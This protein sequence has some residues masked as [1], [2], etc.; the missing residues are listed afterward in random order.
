MRSK[1]S[2]FN[3]GV[4]LNLLKRYWPLWAA[5]FVVLLLI[6]PAQLS[7]MVEGLAAGEMLN[8]TLLS[9]G[10]DMALLSMAASPLAALAMYNYLYTPRGCGMMNC[11]P[12]R[13]ETVFCTAFLTGIAPMLLAD[14]LVMLIT[15]VGFGGRFVGMTELLLWLAIVVMGNVSFYGFAVLCALLT[16]NVVAMP[17]IYVVLN[18]AAY[19]AEMCIRNLLSVFVYGMSV[20]GLTFMSFSPFVALPAALFVNQKSY[21]DMDG[22]VQ[23]FPNAYEVSGLE[24]LG[25][26]C[27][28]GLLCAVLALLLYRRRH[29]ESA[30]D[31]VAVPILKP[32][33]RYCMA[34][35]SAVLFAYALYS[36]MV[37]KS[38]GGMADAMLVL[39]LMMIG[40]FLGYY[41]AEMLMQKTLKVFPGKWKGYVATCLVLVAL[42]VA[43]E[44]DLF[45]YE[46]RIPDADEVSWVQLSFGNSALEEPENIS[47]AVALHRSILEN[48]EE[49]E[50]A[51]EQYVMSIRY[52][53][54]DGRI[55]IRKYPIRGDEEARNDTTSDIRQFQDLCNVYEARYD[56]I[57]PAFPVEK[58]N[59]S[60]AYIYTDYRNENGSLASSYLNLSDEQAFAL[61]QCLLKDLEAGTAGKLWAVTNDEYLDTVSNISINIDFSA[62]Y[63]SGKWDYLGE[64]LCLNAENALNWIRE[65]T[66]LEVLSQRQI[67]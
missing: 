22:V 59:I 58:N 28:A 64:Q 56:R 47:K 37:N 50:Q 1:I 65:N 43:W 55:L 32:V 6:T 40:A 4:S 23:A 19:G 12:L 5:Y 62:G 67:Q 29:M 45:G 8:Y 13:R 31:V 54:K 16:G 52:K 51:E 9:S 27:A 33:F 10:R 24:L 42:T 48:K 36:W 18:L 39:L 34:F 66:D 25:I 60:S 14:V 26:Y 53:F 3:K 20:S 44:Y 7:G 21:V 17:A 11:L 57:V 61:Y 49:N 15:A 35:G 38:F 41:A 2:F 30:G 63:A 46:R